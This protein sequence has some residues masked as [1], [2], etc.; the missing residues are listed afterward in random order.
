MK[1]ISLLNH[2]SVLA[3][4]ASLM[5]QAANV[6]PEIRNL[7]V[8]QR[9]GTYLVDVIFDLVDPDSLSGVFL[10]LEASSD[11]GANFNLPA[12]T[13]TGDTGLI[14]P[15][16]GK[17]MVWDAFTDWP[18]KYTPNAK[19]RILANDSFPQ[20]STQGPDGFVWIPPGKFM[21]G[22][23]IG[24]LMRKSDEILHEVYI[25]PGF[26]MS[27]HEVTQSE[28]KSV[29][30][31]IPLQCFPD[32]PNHPVMITAQDI[33]IDY[34][35]SY[36]RILTDRDRMTGKITLLQE[37]RLPTEAEWEYACRAGTSG[38]RYGEIDKIA[39]WG[40]NSGGQTHPV[41]QKSPNLWGLYDMLGNVNEICADWF[42]DYQIGTGAN[43]KGPISGEWNVMRGGSWFGGSFYHRSANRD[44]VYYIG[45]CNA[46]CGFRPVLS[47]VR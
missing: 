20:P 30:G 47:S 38:L 21:M 19:V 35:N 36:C 17:K 40:G 27:D 42:G 11:N 44:R 45:D 33:S 22:T 43:P 10:S 18:D 12:K 16:T 23:P 24:E 1:S 14:K 3:T 32:Q 46:I 13:V 8:Q 29:M 15:G 28:Y 37:Y 26:W 4:M 6:P 5:V 41:K 9:P 7:T 2:L 34:A 39:W 31:K 25:A